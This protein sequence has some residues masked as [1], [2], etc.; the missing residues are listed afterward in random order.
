[1]SASKLS[2]MDQLLSRNASMFNEKPN[3][4]RSNSSF[5]SQLNFVKGQLD[6]NQQSTYMHSNT[7]TE[8]FNIFNNNLNVPLTNRLPPSNK[9][10]SY[11][12]P[13]KINRQILSSSI[14]EKESS[15]QR[16]DNSCKNLR[17]NDAAEFFQKSEFK[18]ISSIKK[19][20]PTIEK[21]IDYDYYESEQQKINETP[22]QKI[23][24]SY[25]KENCLLKSELQDHNQ[26][27]KEINRKIREME[28]ENKKL[29]NALQQYIDQDEKEEKVRIQKESEIIYVLKEE[30]AKQHV[31][32]TKLGEKINFLQQQNVELDQEKEKY[33]K[34]CV[35]LAKKLKSFQG[36]K[37]DLQ[38]KI[39][40]IEPELDKQQI[41]NELL[42]QDARHLQMELDFWRQKAE[43]QEYEMLKFKRNDEKLRIRLQEYE[44]IEAQDK[45]KQFSELNQFKAKLKQTEIE[46][47]DLKEQL[48][49]LKAELG[50]S[51]YS[52]ESSQDI[53]ANLKAKLHVET[54][55]LENITQKEKEQRKKIEELE[56]QLKQIKEKNDNLEIEKVKLEVQQ[57]I[58]EDIE[59][60]NYEKVIE[61]SKNK[62]EDINRDQN[63]I[64]EKLQRDLQTRDMEIM[65]LKENFD[66]LYLQLIENQN[67]LKEEI[68]LKNK[69]EQEKQAQIIE[70]N[71][72]KK[73]ISKYKENLENFKQ[74]LTESQIKQP[75]SS[76]IFDNT[77]QSNNFNEKI[78][79]LESTIADVQ[80]KKKQVNQDNQMLKQRLQSLDCQLSHRSQASSSNLS[81][82]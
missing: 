9:K 35:L 24:K 58:D 4:Y 68:N 75:R 61:R 69:V 76:R 7:K 82:Q 19:K 27:M 3:H 8:S 40:N 45:E 17:N 77:D 39:C 37:L 2:R 66:S 41:K 74:N 63:Y 60:A 26:E 21:H 44:D 49:K 50:N 73:E 18:D 52:E 55:K 23:L 62:A 51:N 1:M 65:Q 28:K 25:E 56:K 12:T 29:R 48:K 53:I 59:G 80:N 11:Y 16:N 57:Q 71:Q 5:E 67:M 22:C 38:E 47:Q 78:K 42:E 81:Q 43:D 36:V 54:T 33:Y 79:L 15:Q 10:Q 32:N 20:T 13:Q 46:N 6:R 14:Y 64:I 70:L 34:K 72:I 30:I 31:L